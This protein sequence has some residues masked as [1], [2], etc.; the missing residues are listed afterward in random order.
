MRK[1]A[2]VFCLLALGANLYASEHDEQHSGNYNYSVFQAYSQMSGTNSEQALATQKLAK[3][4]LPGWNATTDKIDGSFIDMYGPAAEVSGNTNASKANALMAGKLAAMGVNVAE[5]QTTRD[6]VANHA[7]YVDFKRVV[8]GHEVVFSRL[9]FRFTTDGRL[10]RV[11]MKAYSQPEQDNQP[12][13]A[14]ADVLAGKEMYQG[15]HTYA[16]DEKTIDGDWVWFPIPT[17]SGY[18]MH[19]AW[20]FRM[21]GTGENEM[22]FDLTG[23][24]DAI[25]GELLYRSNEVNETF[26]VTVKANIHMA[27]PVSATTEVLVPDMRLTIGGNN[28]VTDASGTVSVASANAPTSVTYSVRGPWSRVDV[29]GNTP[30]FTAT[31]NKSVDTFIIPIAD[32]STSNFRAVSAFYHVNKIHDFMKTYWPSFTGMDKVMT[33]NVDINDNPNGSSCNAFYRNNR[34]DINF[35]KPQ[36]SCRAFSIVS[37]IVYHEYGHGISYRF[38][39]DNGANFSNGAMGEASSD[40][41]AMSIN[42]D[43][44]VGDGAFNNGGNIR[45][46]TV[47]AKVYPRDLIGQVHNDGEII[48]GAWWDV[49][50]ATS[51]DTMTKLFTLTHYDL[52]NGPNG[53]EGEIYNDVLIS[54]LMNDDNDGNIGNGSPHF[55]SIVEAFARHGIYLMADAQIEHEE[56]DHQS[57]NTPVTI[58]ANL[59]LGNPAFFDKLYLVY[60]DRYNVGTWDSVV[61]NNT[62]GN[63]YTAQI[64]GYPG[65]AIVDYYFRAQDAIVA[66]G[67]GLPKGYAPNAVQSEL[68]LPYQ[69]GVGLNIA[70]YTVDFEGAI[71]GWQLGTPTETATG[72]KWVQAVPVGT[73]Q[74]GLPI[75]TDKDHTTG[76]GKCLVT[77]NSSSSPGGDDVDNGKTIVVTPYFPIPFHEPVVE[78]YRWYSNDRGSTSN[79]RNDYWEVEMRPMNSQIWVNVDYTRE[80]D[81]RW[82]RRVFRVSEF[83]SGNSDIQLR[84]I[85]DDRI[86]TSA[87]NNGQNIIEAAVDDFIIYEGAPLGVDNTTR[88]L[89]AEIYPNPSDK[90][91][92]VTVPQ[93]SKGSITLYDITGKIINTVSVDERTAQ[94]TINTASLAAGTYMVLIQTQYA[95]QNTKVVVS[96]N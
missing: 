53:T 60:R 15:M 47:G 28:Y 23:Y 46:Y 61:M 62:T 58:S 10:Q 87:T 70:R 32:T 92:N 45:N 81:Q 12:L 35:Y 4:F 29:G 89:Q 14:A 75:Q 34:F 17:V 38:Y 44:V 86:V 64:P 59:T 72:G 49:A 41:W 74:G 79:L 85:A 91:L 8:Q 39:D 18:V 73:S 68:T 2:S 30:E 55:G 65:G 95:I 19:P 51:V 67:Y 63:T 84:F 88:K 80:S 78:Y 54:A 20:K 43:G 21:S 31:M 3:S 16:L 52:P 57:I 24:V 1:I 66:S 27:T 9:S 36:P 76:T 6:I 83:Y 37:D 56:V 25:T 11:K 50:Q 48:A 82:R 7:A 5:W 13:L 90:V 42:R 22:P 40:V 77:G 93:D 71:D 69:Y 96:H 94:Y 33:T 26:D